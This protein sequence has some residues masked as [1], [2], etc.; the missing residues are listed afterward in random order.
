[1]LPEDQK[2]LEREADIAKALRGPDYSQLEAS[3]SRNTAAANEAKQVQAQANREFDM[4]AAREKA[5]RESV[6]VSQPKAESNR[7]RRRLLSIVR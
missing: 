7:Q 6:F 2:R 1:M 3:I 5:M 4:H